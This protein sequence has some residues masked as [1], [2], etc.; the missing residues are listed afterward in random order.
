MDVISP[1]LKH[2]AVM[3]DNGQLD[4]I[5]DEEKQDGCSR[6]EVVVAVYS[7]YHCCDKCRIKE[8]FREG[9]PPE[10]T[11][12]ESFIILLG[13]EIFGFECS[14]IGEAVNTIG[15]GHAFRGKEYTRFFPPCYFIDE[16]II[17]SVVDAQDGRVSFIVE[18][19]R[20]SV[21]HITPDSHVCFLGNGHGEEF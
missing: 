13:I 7:F 6:K 20:F 9:F 4:S 1:C 17:F 2:P 11:D 18:K 21:C 10:E 3:V 12:C 19:D 14:P 15:F 16:Q 5:P 8:V